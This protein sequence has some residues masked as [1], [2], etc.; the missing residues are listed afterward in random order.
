M[1]KKLKK[2]K[3]PVNC[4]LFYKEQGISCCHSGK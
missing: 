1:R 3:K 2:V 4:V